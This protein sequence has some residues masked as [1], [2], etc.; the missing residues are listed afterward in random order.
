MPRPRTTQ[1]KPEAIALRELDA[2]EADLRRLA[3]E[4]ARGDELLHAAA[5]RAKRTDPA[6]WRGWHGRL[7]MFRE[8]RRL[9]WGAMFTQKEI[10]PILAS[11]FYSGIVMRYGDEEEEAAIGR[12]A[13]GGRPIPGP[14]TAATFKIHAVADDGTWILPTDG[15]LWLNAATGSTLATKD[16]LGCPILHSTG[17]RMDARKELWELG[18]RALVIASESH[19]RRAGRPPE[20]WAFSLSRAVAAYGMKDAEKEWTARER[21]ER[22]K[23]QIKM[24][25]KNYMNDRETVAAAAL[26]SRTFP[27][28]RRIASK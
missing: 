28:G 9:L 4:D 7:E 16:D 20:K 1:E 13:R 17:E 12:L 21:R 5:R 2:W 22:I 25:R 8:Y 3:E 19:W 11:G 23:A 27:D 10:H 14:R 15:V 6:P 18:R 24:A 26:Y